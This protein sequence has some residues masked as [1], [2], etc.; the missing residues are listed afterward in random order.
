MFNLAMSRVVS[1]FDDK[2]ISSYIRITTLINDFTA[3]FYERGGYILNRVFEAYSLNNIL[4]G[5]LD[6]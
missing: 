4:E 5:S 2:L 6:E 1:W 3:V